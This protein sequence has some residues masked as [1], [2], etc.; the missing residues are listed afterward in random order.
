MTS[1]QQNKRVPCVSSYVPQ[2]ILGVREEGCSSSICQS[3]DQNFQG[4]THLSES[5]AH[6]SESS[7][8]SESFITSFLLSCCLL[9]LLPCLRTAKAFEQ[10]WKQGKINANLRVCPRETCTTEQI[11]V[12]IFVSLRAVL[13]NNSECKEDILDGIY[14]AF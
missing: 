11:Q 3:S 14:R 9:S 12:C 13:A 1:L 6:L 8:S 4:R 5:R 2:S 10:C 7:F